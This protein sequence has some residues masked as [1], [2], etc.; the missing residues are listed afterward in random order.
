MA[1]AVGQSHGQDLVGTEDRIL[2]LACGALAREVLAV[3]KA[4]GLDHVDLK[5][6]PAELHMRPDAIT[7]A[8]RD[9][10]HRHRPQYDKIF[11]LYADCGTGGL[12]DTMLEEEGVERIA[13]PHC[14]SFFEGNEL[15]AAHAEDEITTFYLTDFLV[16]QFESFVIKP[17]GLDRWPELADTYFAHY[18]KLVYLAQT[19]DLDL[20]EKAKAA[21]DRL[22]LRF[23]RRYTGY[24]DMGSFIQKVA[25]PASVSSDRVEPALVMDDFLSE[26]S[27]P[28]D[29]LVGLKN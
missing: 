17:M 4:N 3:T 27:A 24:G 9:A 20:D 10:I 21:A 18:E 28:T 25:A 13:G 23:E 8:V 1:A 7:D 19:D 15:F 5:C 29:T 11:V 12:L 6:L 14:Y 2:L 16:R 26:V 22:G